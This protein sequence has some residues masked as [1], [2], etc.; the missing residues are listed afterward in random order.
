MTVLIGM[1]PQARTRLQAIVLIFASAEL[2]E[3]G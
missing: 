2:L 3:D 1:G